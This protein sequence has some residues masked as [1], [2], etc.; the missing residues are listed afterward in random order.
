MPVTRYTC[1]GCTAVVKT[2]NALPAGKLIKCPRCAK[3]FAAFASATS[4]A[5]PAARTATAKETK[6]AAAAKETKIAAPQVKT[7]WGT[8]T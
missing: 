3:I 7:T 8:C 2:A 4:V 5:Q 1:P 6:L